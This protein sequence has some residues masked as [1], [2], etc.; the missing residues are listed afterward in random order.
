MNR[1]TTNAVAAIAL[2]GPAH[3]TVGAKVTLTQSNGVIQMFEGSEIPCCSGWGLG[4]TTCKDDCPVVAAIAASTPVVGLVPS[5]GSGV[6]ITVNGSLLLALSLE[7]GVAV[8]VAELANLGTLG[9]DTVVMV[10]PAVCTQGTP[11]LPFGDPQG[12]LSPASASL[13]LTLVTLG[14]DPYEVIG[15][16]VLTVDLASIVYSPTCLGDLNLDGTIDGADL[17]IM[18]ASFGPESGHADLNAD[19]IIDSADLGVLLA[20]W[21]ACP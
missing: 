20:R 19:G 13:E 3:G 5:T 17:G 2:L 21:G 1:I 16:S 10:S 18:L 15:L 14:G 8:G 9:P 12:L 7:K 11:P 6:G 4:T